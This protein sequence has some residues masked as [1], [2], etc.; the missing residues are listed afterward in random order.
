ME[1]MKGKGKQ[2]AGKSPPMEI[3]PN[4]KAFQEGILNLKYY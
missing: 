3:L 1:I 2:M 4:A